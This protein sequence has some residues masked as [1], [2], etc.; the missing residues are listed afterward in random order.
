MLQGCTENSNRQL[1][2]HTGTRQRRDMY[3]AGGKSNITMY[4]PRL[5]VLAYLAS[6]LCSW[7]PQ[8]RYSLLATCGT[9]TQQ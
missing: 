1:R 2:N 6:E 9:E 7:K 8:L 3:R 4:V 5:D